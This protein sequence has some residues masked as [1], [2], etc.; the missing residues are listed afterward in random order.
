MEC[1]RI[2]HRHQLEFFFPLSHKW[3]QAS[4]GD[5]D[6]GVVA[7]PTREGSGGKRA[8]AVAQRDR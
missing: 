1:L 8:V 6:T 5:G 7:I 3:E 4:F 2:H